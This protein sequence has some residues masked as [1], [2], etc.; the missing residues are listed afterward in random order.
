MVFTDITQEELEA[1]KA[2]KTSFER[3]RIG[4]L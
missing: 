2:W 3:G 4:V 1:F